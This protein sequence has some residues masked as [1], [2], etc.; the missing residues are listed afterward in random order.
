M[1]V[2]ALSTAG[3]PLPPVHGVRQRE[4][5]VRRRALLW[6]GSSDVS[7]HH[8]GWTGVRLQYSR[9]IPWHK[10]LVYDRGDG[11]VGGAEELGS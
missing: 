1:R 4:K 2:L 8:S 11:W 6:E 9:E 7:R 3:E 10:L 5:V